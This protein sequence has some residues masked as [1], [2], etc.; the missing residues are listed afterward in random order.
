MNLTEWLK[1]NDVTSIADHEPSFK[2][3]G[4]PGVLKVKEAKVLVPEED[5]VTRPSVK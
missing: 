1:Q 4:A 3:N 2:A 5:P